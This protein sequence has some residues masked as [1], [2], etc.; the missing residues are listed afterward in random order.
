MQDIEMSLNTASFHDAKS[1]SNLEQRYNQF[2][3]ATEK[4]LLQS[5]K[6]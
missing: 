5:S 3:E 4:F 2:K 1:V 6:T